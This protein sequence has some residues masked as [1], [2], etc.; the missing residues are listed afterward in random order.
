MNYVATKSQK[1]VEGAHSRLIDI[2]SGRF[3]IIEKT[4]E[5]SLVPWRPVLGRHL[6]MQISGIVH[7]DSISWTIGHQ[8]SRPTVS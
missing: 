1:K 7:G 8:R 6:A 4:Q 5:F 3:A 2:A